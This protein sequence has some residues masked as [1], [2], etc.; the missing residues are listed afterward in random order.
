VSGNSGGITIASTIIVSSSSA[1]SAGLAFVTIS[2]VD[3]EIDSALG[4]T[5]GVTGIT[6]GSTRG[7]DTVRGSRAGNGLVS[8]TDT[9]VSTS[10]TGIVFSKESS[11]RASQ[12]SKMVGFLTGK[13]G[14]GTS[15][16]S[17]TT[18]SANTIDVLTITFLAVGTGE[19]GSS[20][21]GT[22]GA[23]VFVIFTVLT[24]LSVYN[25]GT[26][27]SSSSFVGSFS[28]SVGG[29]SVTTVSAN[30]V[31]VNGASSGFEC[32][33]GAV[34][35]ASRALLG[36]RGSRARAG[37]RGGRLEETISTSPGSSTVGTDLA[38]GGR[39]GVVNE[40]SDSALGTLGVFGGTAGVGAGA[41]GNG[42]AVGANS[43]SGGGVDVGAS[44][45]RE[46]IP[47]VKLGLGG[48]ASYRVESSSSS[49]SLNVH[50]GIWTN[51][52]GEVGELVL[53]DAED[54]GGTN[55]LGGHKRNWDDSQ[56]ANDED[57]SGRLPLTDC[58]K[59]EIG[60]AHV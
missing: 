30:T 42:A 14:G 1:V 20:G 39:E 16:N 41:V 28:A 49:N 33:G 59:E 19:N 37:S 3:V 44:S 47:A 18:G 31:G 15:I 7:T 29:S 48:R 8:L 54:D 12:A 6:V 4:A 23:A 2:G 58:D 57:E 9:S 35:D 53:R 51:S 34:S 11:R 32:S 26:S 40:I 55:R 46:L 56:N 10:L 27:A 52:Q 45:A 43:D 38:G 5:V 24:S 22:S 17:G 13:A 50:A 21:T 60:R 25:V 36:V